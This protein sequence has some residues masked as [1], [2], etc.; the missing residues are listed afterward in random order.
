MIVR[1]AALGAIMLSLGASTS[2]PLAGRVAGP[3]QRCINQSLQTNAA[4]IEDDD[5]IVY[6]QS[7]RRWWVT[8]PIGG[9]PGLTPMAT[10]IVETY[11]G[12]L[13]QGDRFRTLRAGEIIPSAHCRF[14]VFTP[15]DKPAK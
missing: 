3:P 13:C 12:Q 4:V 15:Y 7:G 9:C 8:H 11:G 10:L 5:T 2:E 14:D 1:I 6:R